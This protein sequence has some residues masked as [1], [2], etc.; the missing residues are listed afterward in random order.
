M[1]KDT[2]IVDCRHVISKGTQLVKEI[3]DICEK[4]VGKLLVWNEW[5]MPSKVRITPDQFK[6]F[7]TLQGDPEAKITGKEIFK[8][9]TGYL[10]EIKVE[11]T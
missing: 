9:T 7:A 8:T 1:S 11:E 5:T 4:A 6:E 2:T 10:F 3:S